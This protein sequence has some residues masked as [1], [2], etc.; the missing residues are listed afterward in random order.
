MKNEEQELDMNRLMKIR[1]EK[2]E[3]LQAK[4]EYPF[5]ITKYDRTHNSQEVKEK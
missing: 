2:L 1:R 4:G 5:A 3:E